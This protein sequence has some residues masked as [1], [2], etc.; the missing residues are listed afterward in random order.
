VAH[1]PK[2]LFADEPTANLD[3]ESSATILGIFGELHAAGQTIIMVTHEEEF[4]KAAERLVKI[5]DG[6]IV[7]DEK[8]RARKAKK[9]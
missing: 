8:A 3:N 9:R 6:R 7:S 5:D 1:D 4:A 2:I